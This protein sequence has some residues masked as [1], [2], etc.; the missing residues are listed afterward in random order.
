MHGGILLIW[1]G[2]R[3]KALAFQFPAHRCKPLETSQCMGPSVEKWKS[4]VGVLRCGFFTIAWDHDGGK[5][6]SSSG[7]VDVWS[8]TST[9]S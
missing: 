9:R 7:C 1:A 8:R 5:S 6:G 3:E 2:G 4:E